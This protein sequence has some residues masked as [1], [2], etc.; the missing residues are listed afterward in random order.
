MA[1]LLLPKREVSEYVRQLASAH[2][3]TPAAIAQDAEAAVRA[4]MRSFDVS[5]QLA[6]Y[7]LQE[8]GFLPK[9]PAQTPPALEERSGQ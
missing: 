1:S 6:T 7:R 4:V 3:T 9:N 5:M 2:G 8:L